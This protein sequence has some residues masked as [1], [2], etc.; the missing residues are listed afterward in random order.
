MAAGDKIGARPSAKERGAI[1]LPIAENQRKATLE[2]CYS[3]Y[4]PPGNNFVGCAQDSGKKPSAAAKWQVE[5]ITDDQSLR[6]IL[7]GQR[8]FG[9]RMVIVLNA[10]YSCFEPRREGIG[11]ADELGIGVGNKTCPCACDR[12]LHREL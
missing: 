7:R 8:T 5:N 2:R 6:N 1:G 11:I 3:V 12:L 9:T 4:A 10:A